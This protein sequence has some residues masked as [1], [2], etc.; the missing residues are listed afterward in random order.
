[1]RVE[2][3]GRLRYERAF[4]RTRD[5]G[6]SLP[7]WN[8]TRF[9]IA[10]I[11]KVFVATV[12]LALVARGEL[13]LD[14][15]LTGIVP[16]WRGTAHAA[17]TLRQV[18]AHDAG[19][20]SGADYRTLLD[21]NVEAFALTEPLAAEPGERV[22][23]SDLGYIALGTIVARAARHGSLA[24]V[25]ETALRGWGAMSTAYIPSGRDREAIPAT[26]TD[27]WRGSVQGVVHDE[28]AYLMGGVAG[29]AGL[30]AD[31]RDVALLGEWYLAALHD[32][33]TPLDRALAREAVREQV[34]DP[35]LRRGL[36]WALKTND[37][38][39]CGA[40]MSAS[41]F[42]HTGFTGTSIWVD[43]D[44]DLNVVLL[45]N[46]VHHGRTDLREVRA[47]VADA[48]VREIDRA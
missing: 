21:K 2:H 36:G 14:G 41:T 29:H 27:A 45:T 34:Y 46:N 9:D 38:N 42:G 22:I 40:L 13:D 47:A 17:I 32:R 28:K 31:A 15:A 20:K 19:F 48:A 4:G 5:D 37:E 25:V 18:L 43:P 8:D 11:T 30:F 10:S 1:V 12:A 39:S 44:R 35:T 7:C 24:S 16:E 33:P 23:Y 6:P 3:R 26:E